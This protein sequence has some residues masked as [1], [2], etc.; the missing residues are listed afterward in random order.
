MSTPIEPT[1][2]HHDPLDA[3]I[4]EY[5]QQVEAGVV[6]D[7]EALLTRHPELADRLRDFFA[8]YDRVDRQAGDLRLSNHPHGTTDGAEQAGELPR[9][10]YFG[11]YELLEVL[12][13]GGMGVVYKARQVSLNR[14][15]A[16]KMIL[17]G[18]LATPRDVARFRAEA[19]AAA[20]LD[21]PH[22]VPIYEVGEH[23]GQQY[24]A[25]RFIEGAS[26]ARQPRGDVRT[27]A[28]LIATVARAVHFAHERGILHR[29]IKPSN[30]LLADQVPFITDFGLAKRLGRPSEL[31]GTGETPGTPRYMAPEQAAGRRDLTVAADVYSLGVVLYERLTGETPFTS[32]NVL[33]LL[34]QVRE[35]QP[36]RPTVL[37]PGLDHD[38]ETICLKCLEKEPA[39]RYGSAAALADDLERWLRGEPILARPVGSLGRFTRWC[40]RNPVVA[41]L[42]GTAVAALLAGT[43]VSTYFA[44]QADRRARA[45]QAARDDLEREVTFGI[46]SA[47][48]PDPEPA[49]KLSQPE[50]EALWR[51]ATTNKRVRIRVLEEALRMEGTASPLRSRAPWLIHGIVGLDLQQRAVAEQLLAQGPGMV[52][53]QEIIDPGMVMP[54]ETAADV[55]LIWLS[56]LDN[57]DEPADVAGLLMRALVE[58]QDDPWNG[59]LS[60]SRK[61]RN[62]QECLAAV[63]SHLKT[64]QARWVY[65]EAA[66]LLNQALAREKDGDTRHPQLATGL[67]AVAEWLEPAEASRVL[68]EALVREY[69]D[70]I[71]SELAQGLAAVA[72]RMEPSEAIRFLNQALANTKDGAIRGPLAAGFATIAVRLQPAEA[73][74]MCTQIARMLN[75]ALVQEVGEYRSHL[76]QGLAAVVPFMEPAEAA[77][78]CADAARLL[79]EALVQENTA[80]SYP[81]LA[82]GLAALAW[83]LDSA[84]ADNLCAGAIRSYLRGQTRRAG[85]GDADVVSILL[86]SLDGEPARQAARVFTRRM[87]SDPDRFCYTSIPFV[88]DVDRQL[89]ESS[90]VIFRA[91]ALKRFCISAM[92]P[93]VH[94]RAVAVAAAIG[95]AIKGPVPSVPLLRTAVEPFSCRLTTQDLVDLLKIPTCIGEVRRVILDQLGN[96]Y[97]R[98]FDTHWDFVRYAQE[99]NLNL[100]FTTPPQRPNRKLPPLFED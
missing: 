13:R 16:L 3:M 84:Q 33:E 50:I 58:A 30:I 23:E 2:S 35:A 65:A 15:V 64:A 40:R 78:V 38:L 56:A 81:K 46:L 22:I 79:N 37:R 86:Q 11:D 47:L 82:A 44:I 21:H 69:D 25:M 10:R 55:L 32:D 97:R 62:C 52:M 88:Q 91:A 24:Y 70:N 17:H 72:G 27:E 34:R 5:L 57:S 99:Q 41:G 14:L 53:P 8:D 76:A 36:Q 9:V 54:L 67:A 39:K 48:D 83:R 80:P 77:G 1:G 43:V 92:R 89:P 60:W 18:Q 96:C 85:M 95:I 7:R 20:N 12:A 66:R 42:A 98:R 45:E 29:D 26:L 74:R 19:E 68:N 75:Q 94:R 6:P 100:D 90:R 93:Q 49:A 71:R 61:D 31:T 73:R 28:R 59:Q 51:L 87:V 63:A 4:A